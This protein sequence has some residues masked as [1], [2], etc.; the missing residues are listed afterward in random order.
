[1]KEITTKHMIKVFDL[2]SESKEIQKPIRPRMMVLKDD[3][4]VQVTAEDYR[5][6]TV[7]LDEERVVES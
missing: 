4:T 3:N 6:L 7:F 1:M 5:Q 2:I